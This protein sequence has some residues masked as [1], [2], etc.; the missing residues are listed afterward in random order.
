MPRLQFSTSI[1]GPLSLPE[2]IQV[3]D[4]LAHIIDALRD[5]GHTVSE[6]IEIGPSNGH[7]TITAHFA[8]QIG[9]ES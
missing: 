2:A 3:T 6:E 8:V 5:Q 9:D 4:V 1:K 7:G